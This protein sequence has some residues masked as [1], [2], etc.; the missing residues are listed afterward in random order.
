LDFQNFLSIK[1]SSYNLS[2]VN[3]AIQLFLDNP[4]FLYGHVYAYNNLFLDGIDAFN[5]YAEIV[6]T[7]QPDIIW[8]SPS[9]ISK[10]LYIQK[11]RDDG[12]YDIRTFCKSSIL[13]NTFKREITYFIRKQES[14]SP[15]IK[16]LTVDG[17]PYPYERSGNDLTLKLI[18]PPGKYSYIDIQY[19]N[20]LDI[21]SI[22][23]SK[24]DLHV[25]LLR[26]LSD[27]RDNTLASNIIGRTF[28]YYYYQKGFYKFGLK[29]LLGLFFLLTVLVTFI[30]WYSYKHFKQNHL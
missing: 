3:I 6:N 20:D 11:L 8:Q 5:K 21:A 28:V 2:Q 30:F 9:F 1:R 16:E 24:N 25:Y 17:Q 12:N 22:D 19:K 15:P 27:F 13:E 7:I 4:I 29:R 26:K 18:I 10:K 23:I 14:F